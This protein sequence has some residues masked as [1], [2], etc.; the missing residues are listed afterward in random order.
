[1]RWC[2]SCRRISPGQPERCH[3][4]GRTWNL[5]LCP[6]GHENPPDSQYCGLCGSA[7]LSEPAPGGYFINWLFRPLN[8]PGLI[9]RMLLAVLGIAL[10]ITILTNIDSLAP[11][12]LAIAFFVIAFWFARRLLP[13]WLVRRVT[14]RLRSA[15]RGKS[16]P[17]G[18]HRR[19]GR[20]TGA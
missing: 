8:H 19:R 11:L 10:V 17:N 18:P 7:R 15:R 5:R 4:C 6:S 14:R 20:K 13:D 2:P 12:L 1:M 3:Y 9:V 16:T